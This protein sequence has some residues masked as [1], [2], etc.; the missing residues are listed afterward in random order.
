MVIA[1]V[2]LG[3]AVILLCGAVLAPLLHR[4]GEPAAA[5]HHAGAGTVP[6]AGPDC[7][8][9]TGWTDTVP[10][11]RRLAEAERRAETVRRYPEAT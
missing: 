2:A 6:P 4:A 3:I 10:R 1:A 9:W 7:D 8:Y 5:R 11:I